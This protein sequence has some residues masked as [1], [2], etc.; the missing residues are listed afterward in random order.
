MPE[1]DLVLLGAGGLAREV[2]EAIRM[3]APAVRPI[4][5]LDDNERLRGKFIGGLPVLGPTSSVAGLDPQ[6]MVLA[7]VASSADPGRRSRLVHRLG[8]ASA[9]YAGVIHPNASLA[10]STRIGVG[11]IVL[12]GVV[13]TCDVTLGRHVTVMPGCVLTHDVVLGDG[14]T[15]A[16]GVQ[17]AGGVVIEADA[18]LGAGVSVREGVRVGSGAVVGMGSVVLQDVP[19]GEVWVGTPAHILRGR[20]GEESG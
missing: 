15:L 4:G 14:C 18:Y 17:L 12:A 16:S 13:A 7:A 3:G 1:L 19:A 9:R 5:Y 10:P 6:V 8:L 11:A 20:P 2:V